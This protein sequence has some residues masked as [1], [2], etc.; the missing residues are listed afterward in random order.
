MTQFD[1]V[2]SCSRKQRENAPKIAAPSL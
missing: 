1:H 2:S